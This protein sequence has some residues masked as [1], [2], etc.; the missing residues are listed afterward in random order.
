MQNYLKRLAKENPEIVTLENYGLSYEKRNLTLLRISKK[1]EHNISKPLIFVDSGIHAMEWIGPSQALYII[2]QLVENPKNSYLIEKVDWIVIPL[3]NPDGYEYSHTTNR[4]WRRTRSKGEKCDGVDP[5]R[6]FDIHWMGAGGSSKE[7][8][9]FYAGPKPFSE[10]ETVAL[11]Q[12]I[13]KYANRT[14]LYLTIHSPAQCLLYPWGYT[15]DPPS[16]ERQLHDLGEKVARAIFAVNA[17]TYDIG[18]SFNTL[19]PAAG[20]SR[21]WAYGV[22]NISLSY[23]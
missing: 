3:L 21:D 20:S 13:H 12:A 9:L 7:C 23:T 14:K 6:N 8:S 15:N 22:A 17:T 18:S 16:N 1:N 4:F 11:S 19:N 2:N 10:P 5:N